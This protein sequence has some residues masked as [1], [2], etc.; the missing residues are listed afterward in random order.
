VF[1]VQSEDISWDSYHSHGKPGPEVCALNLNV[2]DAET[3]GSLGLAGQLLELH[4]H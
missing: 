4:V 3:G 2:E 1:V